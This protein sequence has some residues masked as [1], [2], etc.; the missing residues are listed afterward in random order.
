MT[1]SHHL[2]AHSTQPKIKKIE[3]L[4]TPVAVLTSKV[5]KQPK[6]RDLKP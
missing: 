5:H 1:I 4:N 2:L 3:A 6:K